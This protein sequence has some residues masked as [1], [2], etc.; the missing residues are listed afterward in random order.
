M[1]VVC[2]NMAQ[3]YYLII[4]FLV[5]TCMSFCMDGLCHHCQEQT[6]CSW[7][8]NPS[9]RRKTLEA[10]VKRIKSGVKKG[11]GLMLRT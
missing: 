5:G 10:R 9:W 1:N 2:L 11:A 4:I 7:S 3:E 6:V 8:K